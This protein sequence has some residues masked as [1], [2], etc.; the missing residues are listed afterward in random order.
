MLESRK[1][2]LEV[3][4]KMGRLGETLRE[5]RKQKGWSLAQ[6]EG[7]IRIRKQYLAALEREHFAEFASEGQIRGFLHTYASH[8]GLDPEEI[9]EYYDEEPRKVSRRPSIPRPRSLSPWS[10]MN[11]LILVVIAVITGIMALYISSR[12]TATPPPAAPTPTATEVLPAHTVPRYVLEVRLDYEGHSLEASEQLDFVNLTDD[13]LQELVFNVFPNHADDVFLLKSVTLAEGGEEE[14]EVPELKYALSGTSLRV[15]LPTAL[16]PGDALTLLLE[17]SLDPP[18]MSPY[19]QWGAGS[20]GYSDR[21]LAVGN[22]Y[23]ALAPYKE[24]QGWYSFAYHAVGDPY[25]TEVADYE[26][27]IV[28]PSG[29]TVVGSGAEELVGNRWRYTLPEAR[30]FAFTASDQYLS[31]NEQAGHITVS[32]YYF[33][34]HERSG[35]DAL[36]AA[37]E[38]VTTFEE[39]FGPYPYSTFRVAEVDFAGGMEFSALTFLGDNWYGDHPGGYRSSMVSLLAHEIAHQWWY[40]V[41]G[42]DQVGEPWLDEALATYSSMLYYERRH[43]EFVEWWWET[44]VNDYRPQGEIDRPIYAFV[45]GRT[46]LNA[47]YRRGALF[48][49]DLRDR[50]GDEAFFAFLRD[51]YESKGKQLSTAEDFF[52]VLF[53]HSDVDISSLLEE[54]FG[55]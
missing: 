50:M 20:L 47:V 25:V 43:P 40:G 30:S 10:M 33:A 39:L 18:L 9:L 2:A 5:A 44:E 48:I 42:N 14:E 34:T 46:Y 27:E 13:S 19:S 51:Y 37:V 49:S 12:Q 15:N 35:T 32:S 55:A 21:V 52:A 17:F 26:V 4:P 38:A 7:A 24:G 1:L 29:V 36:A 54:Y 41:V 31:S 23:P 28:A 3:G 8:L 6:V 22:W 53:R 11:L 45:D 16:E